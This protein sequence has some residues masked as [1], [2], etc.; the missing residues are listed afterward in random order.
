ML[1]ALTASP[2]LRSAISRH[3]AAVNILPLQ[4][5]NGSRSLLQAAYFPSH[6]HSPRWWIIGRS[7]I[8][9]RAGARESAG[10]FPPLY[11]A[12]KFVREGNQDLVFALKPQLHK[13]ADLGRVAACPRF[14]PAGFACPTVFSRSTANYVFPRVRNVATGIVKWFNATKGY[15]FISPTKA[16]RDVF[17]HISAVEERPEQPQ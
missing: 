7:T 3:S 10:R 4:P 15:G 2:I 1:S 9:K 11:T 8:V 17:V 16:A 13:P 12:R 6:A 5:L 14:P